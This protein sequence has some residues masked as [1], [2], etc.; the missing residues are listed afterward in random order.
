MVSMGASNL[1]GAML[2]F[3]FVRY[4]IPIAETDA[5]IADRVRNFAVFAVYLVFAGIVSLGAAAIT[6]RSVVRWQ[7]RGGPPTRAEQMAALHAPLR[8]AIVHLGLWLLGGVLFVF[9]TAEEMPS[10]AVAVSVTV[11]MAAT[12][13]FGFTYMLGERILRPVAAR[14]LSEGNFD[15]TMAPGVGTRLAMTW[16]LGTLMP[17]AG[18]VLLCVTQLS[19]DTDFDAD[20]LALSVLA[21]AVTSIGLALVLSLLT[22]AQISDPIKQLRWA[23]ER[24]QR[25]A[26]GVQV[27]VFDGSEIGRLQVGFNRMMA[28]SD[29]RRRLRELFGQHVGEDV[30]RRALQYGTEL[31]GET[32]YVAVLFVDMVGSTATAAERPP[33]EVVELLNE[34]F[35]VVVEVVDR[36][37]GFVNK[38]M[39]DAALVIF[40]AP[41]DRPDAPTAALAAARELRF[42]LDEITGLDVGIGVSAGLAVA[43]NIGAAERFEYTV[44][45][46]P[47]NEA[48]RLTE[49]AKMRPSRVLAS[50]SALYFA[51]DEER[52]HWELG[53]EVQLRGRRRMTHLAWPVRYPGAPGEANER[54]ESGTSAEE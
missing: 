40:G 5:I 14:A 51:D 26:S 45:G 22:S 29:E 35:R 16:G 52:S 31:G 30:A 37:H 17:V 8:Q 53:D 6:L 38:F 47:V 50:S 25:G 9:L 4:G 1:F 44:I 13:T 28:E 3:A 39:G 21:L 24:V 33:S 23:I 27:E 10:L 49:L 43:G 46:D 41:L 42:A 19:A 54:D 48:S 11:A 18:I 7:L 2:V 32:R 20:A 12:S 34:F 36:H 15:R